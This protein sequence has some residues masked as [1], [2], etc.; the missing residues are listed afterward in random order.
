MCDIIKNKNTRDVIEYK[1]YM[2]RHQKKILQTQQTPNPLAQDPDEVP[3]LLVHSD[4]K[5]IESKNTVGTRLMGSRI[6]LSVR[7]CYQ[8][9]IV[10][11]QT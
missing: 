8:S 4:L 11:S 10:V 9:D 7:Q 5:V 1:K 6:L 3:P 2:W